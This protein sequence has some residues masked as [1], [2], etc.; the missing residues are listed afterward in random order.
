MVKSLR[1][2]EVKLEKMGIY[3]KL[4]TPVIAIFIYE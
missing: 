4:I 2:K 3:K 1:L